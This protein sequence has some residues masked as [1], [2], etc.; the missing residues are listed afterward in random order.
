MNMFANFFTPKQQQQG[1]QQQGGQQQNNQQTPPNGAAP[2]GQ[3]SAQN[4]Q[5]MNN[6]KMPGSSSEPANP[7]DAYKSLWDNAGKPQQSEQAPSFNL[8]PKLVGEVSSKINFAEG[9]DQNMVQQAL[10]GDIQAF[11]QVLNSVG[12]NAYSQSL[13]HGSTLTDKFVGARSEFEAKGL[14]S[15]VKGVLTEQ[16]VGSIPN[17]NHPVVKQQ[18]RETAKMF[19]A[20]YP[21][22]SPQEIAQMAQKYVTDLA[23][24]FQTQNQG[25]EGQKQQQP[26]DTNWD[27][28]L[29]IEES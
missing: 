4:Q 14:G 23:S 6:G 11:M 26:Q 12:R 1:G 17:A 8:D 15:K 22:A 13:Q 21:E 5:D 2:N 29:G 10:G 27:T 16:A 7:L 3:Q 9:I 24:A 18:L 19:A 25:Q 28:W 20:Q